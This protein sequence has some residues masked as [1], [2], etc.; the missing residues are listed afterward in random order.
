[1]SP[2]AA[3][4]PLLVVALAA[5]VLRRPPVQAAA[6]GA[7]SAGAVLLAAS[8]PSPVP[9]AVVMDTV[10]L[11]ASAGAVIA[12]GLFFVEATGHRGATE[13]IGTW[14]RGLPGGSGLKTT[15]LVVGLAP[16]LESLTGF[17]VSLVVVVPAA[18]AMLP[19]AAALRTSLVALNVMPWGTLGLATLVG[20]QLAGLKPAELGPASALTSAGVFPLAAVLASALAG[21]RH[22]AV[23]LGSAALGALFS[24]VL[25]LANT[26]LGVAVAGVLAGLA[27]LAA[28]LLALR[29]RGHRLPPPPAAAWPYAALLAA[30]L[31]QQIALQRF[32]A[33]ADLTIDGSTNGWAPLTSPALALLAAGL[34]AQRGAPASDMVR[35]A[36]RRGLTPVGALLLFVLMAQLMAQGGMVQSLT[37]LLRTASGDAALALTAGL[38][39]VAGYMTGSN[40]GGNALLM[41]PAVA[42]GEAVGK[43]LL[44]AA[45]QNSAAGHA[46][47]AAVPMVALLCGLAGADRREQGQLMRFGVAV[48][49]LNGM[50]VALAAHTALAL[51][52]L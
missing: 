4:I 33:L 29:L 9:G 16:L 44:F 34:L 41:A 28:A 43:P 11:T 23:L 50:A 32:P 39:L 18:L 7:L 19:R 45:V 15:A 49:L 12:A 5:L 37:G 6:A 24:G 51:G 21:A 22:A 38:G 31:M 8:G 3:A 17:G 25:W 52:V 46:V 35:A 40:V 1:M 48:A 2:L 26:F 47:L 36:S 10:L 14:V 13:A 27:T 42:L 30:A 20:A